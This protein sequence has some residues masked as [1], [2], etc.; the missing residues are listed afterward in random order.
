MKQHCHE[1][2][3]CALLL[4]LAGRRML[5]HPIAGNGL[6]VV[7]L[8]KVAAMGFLHLLTVC[9]ICNCRYDFVVPGSC[10]VGNPH[11]S[12]EVSSTICSSTISLVSCCSDFDVC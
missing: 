11:D 8:A 5:V 12:K 6:A 7:V 9:E 3:Y 2:F 1:C 10:F 4:L